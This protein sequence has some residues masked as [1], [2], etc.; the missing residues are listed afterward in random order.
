MHIR[1]RVLAVASALI[2]ALFFVAAAGSFAQDKKKDDRK[3]DKQQQQEIA[4]ALQ[5][6]DGVAAGQPAPNDLTLTWQNHSLKARD[7]R[8]FVP[9]T[10]AIDKLTTPSVIY[11]IRVTSKSAAA[12]AAPAAADAKKDDKAK[13]EP[14]KVEYVFEDVRFLD[15]KAPEAGQPYR[16]Q[17]AFSVPG[18]EY[19]VSVLVRER[20][21]NS[22]DKKAPPP[23]TVVAKQAVTVPNYWNDELATSSVLI[24][25]K[26]E[27]LTAAL[28]EAEI[29]ANPYV[30]GLTR[31]TPSPDNKFTKKDELS[32]LFLVYNN[33]IDKTSNKPNV[34]VDY[35]FYTK[36]DGAEKF[37]NKTNPQN[38]DAQ[39]LPPQFD[40]N[41]GHQLVGGLSVPL[42]SFPE[43]E[44]RLE[45]K[46]TDKVTG[47]SKVENS[48]FTVV[49]G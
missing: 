17:R 33:G 12:P 8:T 16:L 35:N 39:T 18:G 31:L 41:A 9:F 48:T 25:S 26:T 28:P 19:D 14:A 4:A 44:Y 7:Q 38:F 24:A 13:K 20:S 21:A 2:A 34:T 42:T 30:F 3:F 43:G 47:K 5:T 37:F 49:A 6:V 1:A 40:V 45:I 15:L 27:Q 46:V 10:I 36:K 23:R 22:K 11:Y 32:I 29:S